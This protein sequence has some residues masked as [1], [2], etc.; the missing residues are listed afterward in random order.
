MISRGALPG[1]PAR[2][3][4]GVSRSSLPARR[5]HGLYR[6]KRTPAWKASCRAVG[7]FCMAPFSS[8]SW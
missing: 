7:C 1:C 8:I 4:G 5:A 6:A 3:G 2:F